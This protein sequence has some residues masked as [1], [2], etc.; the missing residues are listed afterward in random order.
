MPTQ[1]TILT[2]QQLQALRYAAHKEGNA[3]LMRLCSLA[4]LGQA[5]AMSEVAHIYS[6]SVTA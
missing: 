1:S 3:A 4:A 5:A 6:L 2:A